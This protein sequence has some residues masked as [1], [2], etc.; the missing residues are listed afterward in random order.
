VGAVHVIKPDTEHYKKSRRSSA[1]AEKWVEVHRWDTTKECLMAIKQAGYKILVTSLSETSKPLTDFDWSQPTAVVFG[2]EKDGVS[3]LALEMADA[4][5]CIPMVGFVE[6][7]NISVANALV[8]YHAYMDRTARGK[9][10]DM[11]EVSTMTEVR[12]EGVL[13]GEEWIRVCFTHQGLFHT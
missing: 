8:L 2:N 13:A 9:H 5:I 10:G 12:G 1:G 4:S 11:T 7:Y 6:S 3:D